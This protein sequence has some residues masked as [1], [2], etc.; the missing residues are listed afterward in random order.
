MPNLA[1]RARR[2]QQCFDNTLQPL[3]P[4]RLLAAQ[5]PVDGEA[6]VAAPATMHSADKFW[7]NLDA[8][9]AAR[10]RLSDLNLLEFEP[11]TLNASAMRA[12]LARAPME[13]T[14]AARNAPLEISIPTPEG[15]LARFNIQETYVLHPDLAAKFPDI[16]TYLGKG[17][18]DP[19]ANIRLDFTP[20]GFHASVF[21]PN[22][23]YYVDP[24]FHLDQSVY[25]SYFR[26]DARPNPL[27]VGAP[28]LDVDTPH[29]LAY[30]NSIANEIE[31]GNT[32]ETTTGTQ[33]RTYRLACAANGEYT[34][35]F[36][37]TV[38]AG[39]S[40]VTTAINRVNQVYENDLTIRLQLIANNNTII[41]TNP[42]TDPYVNNSNDINNNQS[43]L[44]VVIGEANY[45]IGHVFTTGSG[46]IAGLGVVGINGQKA[47]GTT[48]LP[49]PTG[50]AFYIDFV[51]HEMGHQF[52]A[53]HSFNGINGNCS[54][55]RSSVAAYEPGSGST[56]MGYAGI[57]GADDLQS[58]SHAYFLFD[59]QERILN[60]VD[61]SIP[62]VGTRTSTGNTAP[63]VDA[64]LNYAIPTGTPFILTGS[65]SDP[66]G[67]SLTYA[68]EERDLGAAQALSAADNGASPIVRSR[69]P[70]VNNFRMVPPL[71]IVLAGLT[72]TIGEKL[73]T[74]ARSAFRWR[75][76]VRDNRAGGGGIQ[77][78]DMQINVVNTGASFA[79]TNFNSSTTIDV[80]STQTLTW[81]VAGT[82]ASP[83]STPN[84]RI[85]MS[86][87]GGINF[88]IELAASTPNDGSFDF[89]VPNNVGGSVRFKVEGVDNIFFDINNTNIT[90]QAAANISATP[91]QP[92]LLPGSDTGQFNNDNLTRLNNSN[93]GNVLQFDVPGTVPGATVN[94]LAN[95][96]LVGTAVATGT[97]T[98]VTTNGSFTIADG[99]ATI[100]ARQTEPGKLQS[101]NSP[102]L[103][104]TIDTVAPVG[105]LLAFNR[106]VG[107]QHQLQAFFTKDVSW[108]LSGSDLSVTNTSG[109]A[110]VG[111]P[112]FA[113]YASNTATFTFP[114]RPLGT[115]AD[116]NYSASVPAAAVQDIAGNSLVAPLS[117]NF[118]FLGGDANADR[119]VNISDFSV[120][121]SNFNLPANFSGGDFNYS[122]TVEIGDFA[123][124]AANYNVTLPPARPAAVS[125][126]AAT[127]R[128][129]SAVPVGHSR[130]DEELLGDRDVLPA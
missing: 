108:S 49:S 62:G 123:I 2:F 33:L 30:L 99:A 18:D 35:F 16:K 104:I 116:G 28:M 53:P 129:F 81:N 6:V 51:A 50:D 76:T 39:L 103:G 65:A 79:I 32:V 17:V 120:L 70:S 38:T 66:N 85:T 72:S 114:D 74:V 106:N 77:T 82:T 68:W 31:E 44:P 11:F 93:A 75:L 63:T 3:E 54:G 80:G 7:N 42:A 57:C 60:F 86:T 113:S 119:S 19:Y 56:I 78:D 67:D 88:P 89:V 122:G 52:G 124:L 27:N 29:D 90:I 43:N 112:N 128:T 111:S 92:D 117:L 91:G 55:N 101:G 8:M 58:F 73:P 9:P 20:L 61:G 109:G 71:G 5:L 24:Y 95:G 34:Q 45:D 36:G 26:M 126:P 22:G 1:S 97:T 110:G 64:G 12:K 87:D 84:V 115:L 37:G 100:I 69:L 130:I 125:A 96:I 59:S 47:R 23:A 25:A 107:P 15:K 13:F 121:A 41:Y 40:A 21:S 127:T 118:F 98:T 83:I 102:S 46:G 105:A 14:A 94:V 4:R 10:G 48:G